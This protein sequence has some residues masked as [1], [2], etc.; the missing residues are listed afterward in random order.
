[1]RDVE[2]HANTQEDFTEFAALGAALFIYSGIYDMGA[3]RNDLPVACKCRLEI[4]IPHFIVRRIG[5]CQ[6]GGDH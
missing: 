4:D 3:S 5:V 2:H 1:L 6:V